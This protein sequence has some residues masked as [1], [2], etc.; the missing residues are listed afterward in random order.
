MGRNRVRLA[1][2]AGLLAAAAGLAVVAVNSRRPSS[3]GGGIP[4][5]DGPGALPAPPVNSAVAPGG[6]GGG[7]LSARTDSVVPDPGDLRKGSSSS[8]EAL[9]AEAADVA[10]R[11]VRAYPDCAQAIA[12]SA[13][14]HDRFRN[15]T[16]AAKCWRRCLKLDPT[17]AEAHHGLGSIA[18]KLGRYEEAEEEFR[19]AIELKPR[20]SEAYVR[21]AESL[22]NRGKMREAAAALRTH[23]GLCASTSE[24]CYYLGQ[25][26]LYLKEFGQAQASYEAAVRLDPTCTYAYHG[27]AAVASRLGEKD[28]AG[29]Y[30]AEFQRLKEKDQAAEKARMRA[31]DDLA[32]FRAG[33]AL[34]LTAAGQV[35]RSRGDAR[36]AED[37]WRRAAEYDPR[38]AACR[39]QLAALYQE[40]G[41][42]PETLAALEQLAE[43]E[44]HNPVYRVGAGVLSARLGQ[45]D[46]AEKSF[47]KAVEQAPDR[48]EGYAA[49]VQLSLQTNRNLSD[50]RQFALTAARLAPTAAN[51]AL[52]AAACRRVGDIPGARAAMDRAIEKDPANSQ[53]RRIRK[54]LEEKSP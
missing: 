37:H 34:I 50:V 7:S 41:R 1:A 46:A 20:L 35:Y 11:L 9:R 54:S 5:E 49:L 47:R 26:Y 42:L 21:L 31:Y 17:F 39:E 40:S 23:A 14:V 22:M 6:A 16:E 3:G 32:A 45:V 15:T 51:D 8:C 36:E 48:H 53:Y 19:R 52:L 38:N 24:S 44:P 10:A 29:R 28:K 12:V 33:V 18:L 43:I 25:A 2:V 30:R 4:T 27:L 13:M